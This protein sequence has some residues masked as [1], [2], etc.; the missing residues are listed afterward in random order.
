MATKTRLTLDEFLALPEE[1]PYAEFVRGEVRRK[2]AP[3]GLHQFIARRLVR[4]LES[5]FEPRGG[6]A[7]ESLRLLHDARE[8][9]LSYVPDVIL[10]C[11]RHRFRWRNQQ[12]PP[13]LVVEIRSD[14]Q[15][16]RLLRDKCE[17]YIAT[18]VRTAWLI[19]PVAATVEVYEPQAPPR[20]LTA[21][22]SLRFDS[23]VIAL[24][25]LLDLP[26]DIEP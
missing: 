4:L 2:V 26:D 14:R 18:G 11:D 25:A 22:D 9:S 15:S 16:L 8:D 7:L 3:S 24:E 20:L 5:F 1:K 21:G 6:I 19:D 23:F 13:D 12:N 17:D 10:Y